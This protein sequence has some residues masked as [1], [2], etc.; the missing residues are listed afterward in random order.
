MRSWQP[1]QQ[2]H[3]YLLSPLS[4]S[5]SLSLSRRSTFVRSRNQSLPTLSA[6][7]SERASES[8]FAVRARKIYKKED[9]LLVRTFASP[10]DI[11][12]Y[13]APSERALVLRVD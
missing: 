1:W 4:L 2:S 12:T 13:V 7:E 9:R 5:L 6:R 3:P 11:T 10:L 8:Q